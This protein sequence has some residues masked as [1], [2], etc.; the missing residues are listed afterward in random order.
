M[1]VAEDG[2]P[3]LAFLDETGKI[4]YQLPQQTPAK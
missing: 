2:N 1:S 4:T 3:I